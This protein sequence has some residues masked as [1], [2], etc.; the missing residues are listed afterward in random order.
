M[1]QEFVCAGFMKEVLSGKLEREREKQDK[2]GEG[3]EGIILEKG[4]L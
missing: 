4:Q 1:T 2:V 3:A